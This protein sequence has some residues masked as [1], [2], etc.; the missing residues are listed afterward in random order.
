MTGDAAELLTTLPAWAF[1]FVMVLARIG[2]AMALL[3][4][5]GEP[6][7]PALVRVGLAVG[8]TALLLPGVAPS[9]PPVPEASVQAAAMVAATQSET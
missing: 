6:Q 5:L 1:A 3:P 2:G 7:P 8:V 9:I 4:G